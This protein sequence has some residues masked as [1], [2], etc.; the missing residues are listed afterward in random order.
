MRIG[1]LI[2]WTVPVGLAAAAFGASQSDAFAYPN[3]PATAQLSTGCTSVTPGSSCTFTF[4]FLDSSGAGD[5][6]ES[7]AFAVHTVPGC[8]LNPTSATTAG[9]GFASTTLSCASNAGT[10]SETITATAG[11]VVA[12]VTIAISAGGSQTGASLPNTSALQPG[13]SPLLIGGLALAGLVVA[14]GGVVLTR[15]SHRGRRRPA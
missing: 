14:G 3:P 7:V 8:S 4:Q 5:N 6:G 13:P 2:L 9:G 1:R 11:S 10:G 15:G 12:S